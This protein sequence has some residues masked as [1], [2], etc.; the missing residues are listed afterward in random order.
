MPETHNRS[1]ELENDM[2]SKRKNVFTAAY[3]SAALLGASAIAITISFA[4]AAYANGGNGGGNGGGNS[5]GNSSNGRSSDAAAKGGSSKNERDSV[6]KSKKSTVS[7]K[8]G[9]AVRKSGTSKTTAATVGKTSSK[10][11]AKPNKKADLAGVLGVHPS[12]LGALN[13]AHASAQALENAN[14][15]SRVGRIAAYRDAVLGRADLLATYEA[16]RAALDAA[17]PPTRD[18][19]SISSDLAQ[20]DGD[21]GLASSHLADLQTQLAAVP[22]GEDTTALTDEIAAVEAQ[23]TTLSGDRTAVQSE[24]TSA[25]AYADLVDQEAAQRQAI[26]DQPATEL[27]LLEAAANKPVTDAVVKAV[28]ALLGLNPVELLVP[29]TP[30]LPVL[31]APV[32]E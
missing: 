6:A 11:T 31:D 24:L 13:A 7:E 8:S 30:I 12:E 10:K 1:T 2:T 3:L 22:E 23:I 4:D 17:T 19:A 29:E 32:A 18:I 14:P 9:A 15:N 27:S 28:N 25:N 5:N 26:T 20:I 21:L 16:T